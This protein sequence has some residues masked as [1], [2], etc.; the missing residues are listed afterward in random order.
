MAKLFF[1]GRV[2]HKDTAPQSVIN[3]YRLLPESVNHCDNKN[4][5][6]KI[7]FSTII[8]LFT[9]FNLSAQ[10]IQ[11]SDSGNQAVIIHKI[12]ITGNK[13]TRSHIIKRELIFH[14]GDTLNKYT[15]DA[16]FERSKENL[17]NIGLF[18]FVLKK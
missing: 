1:R 16:A 8:S 11:Q 5:Y 17:M 13:T 7:F 10:S 12:I 15:L 3:I 9:F 2:H 18:H 4:F 14:E 6:G